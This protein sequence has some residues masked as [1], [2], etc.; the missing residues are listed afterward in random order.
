MKL[1]WALNLAMEMQQLPHEAGRLENG[2]LILLS[3]P[4]N[5]SLEI[6]TDTYIA[7]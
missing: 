5:S 2:F 1:H 7:L 6:L 4:Q 3:T